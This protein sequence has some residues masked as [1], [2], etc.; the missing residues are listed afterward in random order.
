MESTPLDVLNPTDSITGTD[1]EVLDSV[2]D[3]Y[4]Q[5]RDWVR[6][7][8]V[9]HGANANDRRNCELVIEASHKLPPTQPAEPEVEPDSKEPD[10]E[11]REKGNSGNATSGI[12]Q[13]PHEEWRLFILNQYDSLISARLDVCDRIRR[14]VGGNTTGD[15]V[16]EE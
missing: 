16:E 14:M 7:A 1:E 11:Q 2:V 3:Y 13:V 9:I 12:Q 5:S 15:I 4:R 6:R 8:R 10:S